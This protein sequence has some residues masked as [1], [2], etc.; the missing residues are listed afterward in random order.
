VGRHLKSGLC[1]QEQL[2]SEAFRAWLDRLREPFRLHRKFW[3][4]GYIAQALHERGML[5]PGR[6]GLGFGVGREPLPALFASLGCEVVA[7][8]QEPGS[9]E[10]SGWVATGQ[11]AA[12][13]DALND[14]GICDPEAFRR[15]V[16]FRHVDMNAIPDDLRG[17]DFTWS[18]C[19]FEHLGSIAN[20]LRF[21]EC[22]MDCLRPG[23]VAVHTTEFNLSSDAE[24]IDDNDFVVLFRRRDILEMARRLSAS[25]HDIELDLTP[26]DR[27]A[28]RHV[29]VPPYAGAFHIR[30]EWDGFVT[31]SVGLIVRKGRG[32]ALRRTLRR[33]AR[34]I[35]PRAA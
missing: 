3:E 4:F 12:G 35:F 26:G 16:A 34:R 25:G 22:Q 21:L 11:H 30:L 33:A 8:D 17:F 29:D 19:C 6:R 10:Q 27:V 7:S 32:G 5:R 28:D 18:S 20:G 2:E 31:T 14:R 23:G 15:R 24:T 13:L 9:A 1:T